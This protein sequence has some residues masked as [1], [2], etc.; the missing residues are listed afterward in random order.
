MSENEVERYHWG[1]L[2]GSG[3]VG[4]DGGC[5]YLILYHGWCARDGNVCFLLGLD[6]RTRNQ[7]TI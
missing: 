2:H 1:C 3:C 6:E 4:R 5:G 7:V